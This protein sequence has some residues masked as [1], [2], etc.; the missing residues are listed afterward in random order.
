MCV[1]MYMYKCGDCKISN[2]ISKNSTTKGHLYKLHYLVTANVRSMD[3]SVQELPQAKREN[4]DVSENGLP[5]RHSGK[6]SACGH[7]R[8]GFDPWVGKIPW[9]RKWQPTAVFLPVKFC[10]CFIARICEKSHAHG[11]NGA[12]LLVTSETRMLCWPSCWSARRIEKC[13]LVSS[14]HPVS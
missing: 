13:S 11:W 2:P 10:V 6:E 5:N 4:W 8:Q 7:W 1:C 12:F 3:S 9:R 14:V